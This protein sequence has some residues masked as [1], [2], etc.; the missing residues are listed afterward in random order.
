MPVLNLAAEDVHV[1]WTRLDARSGDLAV[2]MGMLSEAERDRAARL[3]L[4]ADRVAFVVRRATLRAILAAYLDTDPADLGFSVNDRGRPTL[5]GG[6]GLRFSLS[7][8]GPIAVYAIA[9]DRDVG[10]DVEAV[11]TARVADADLEALA[12]RFFSVREYEEL[13]GL[14]DE[15]RR[16]GFFA[17]WTRKEAF[18]KATGEGLG[19]G[20]DQFDV[21]V[22]ADQPPRVVEIRG[23]PG[24]AAEWSLRSL[25]L[26]A[27]YAGALA[28]RGALRPGPWPAWRWS[29]SGSPAGR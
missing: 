17:C 14:P 2:G 20:L 29:G 4:E 5:A 22:G 28:V 11:S 23:R 16:A 21:T 18:L 27:G 10:V 13:A 24:E 25:A 15:Q 7:R 8:S 1:W 19:G 9:G 12:R 6:S 3:R 26:P